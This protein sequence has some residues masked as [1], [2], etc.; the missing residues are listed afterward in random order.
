MSSSLRGRL[1]L[2]HLI[3]AIGLVLGSEKNA[4][5]F[6]SSTNQAGDV[7]LRWRKTNCVFVRPNAHGSRYLSP[8]SVMAA[9]QAAL[10]N[11]IDAT[12]H[13]SYINFDVLEESDEAKPGFNKD[14]PYLNENV[15]AIYSEIWPYDVKDAP[16]ITTV[17][18]NEADGQILDADVEFNEVDF[19]F[20][21]TDEEGKYDLENTLTHELGHLLGLDHPCDDGKRQPVPLDHTGKRIPLCSP[22]S[23]LPDWIKEATMYN[24]TDPTDRIKRYPHDDEI[25]GICTLYPKPMDP[26]ECK[27]PDFSRVSPSCAIEQRDPLAMSWMSI[28]PLLLLLWGIRYFR[29]RFHGH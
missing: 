9:Y 11:W 15:I 7:A 21:T 3:F 6:V 28:W 19:N 13:C 8:V 5:A 29:S 4:P 25:L 26:G 2:W 12:G 23:S 18:F 24:F 10:K 14:N 27:T 1:L 17:F 22:P 16:A 20:T